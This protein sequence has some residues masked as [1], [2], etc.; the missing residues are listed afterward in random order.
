MIILGIDP[1][2]QRTGAGLIKKNGSNYEMVHVET[3]RMK[4]TLPLAQKLLQIYKSLV[5]IIRRFHPDVLALEN[6]FFGKDV[7]AMVKIGEAR[8][9]AM[10]AAAEMGIEVVEYPPARIKQSITG[11]GQATKE[12]M[13]LMVGRLLNL[14]DLPPSDEADAL[15][16]AL[17][18]AHT[19]SVILSVA[20]PCAIGARI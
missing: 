15:A 11:N 12:Q 6:V 4:P 18:H 1:G 20:N 2:T 7:Q 16:V 5:E 10:L 9:C 17:C 19:N 3:I 13:Q 14:K 8:A